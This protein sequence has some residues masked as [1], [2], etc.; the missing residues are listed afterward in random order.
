MGLKVSNFGGLSFRSDSGTSMRRCA[1][2]G[3]CFLYVRRFSFSFFLRQFHLRR[4]EVQ[5]TKP[6][7]K[8]RKEKR[9]KEGPI[10][11]DISFSSIPNSAHHLDGWREGSVSMAVHL[12]RIRLLTK[13]KE[14]GAVY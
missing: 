12:P 14:N 7:G 9:R 10:K 11:V 2:V 5:I 4:Q 13:P 6:R 8:S 1:I 3:N